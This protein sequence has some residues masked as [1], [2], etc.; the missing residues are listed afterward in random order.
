MATYLQ[1][2]TDYI[3]DYQPFQPNLNFYANLLQAKQTQYD[4][5]YKAINNLY[6]QLY[7]ADLTRTDNI[8]KKDNL[9]KQIDYNLKR[10]SGL[11]LSLQQNVDQATQVFRPFYDDKYLMKDMAWTK[12]FNNTYN[13]AIGLKNSS[14]EK[15]SK[16]YW[17]TGVKELQ[18]RREEFKDAA[19]DEA[20]NMASPTYTSYDN[21]MEK[22]LK[23]AKDLNLSVDITKPD[24]SGLYFIRQKNGELILPTL[25]KLFMST[26][27]TDPNLQKIYQTQA[28]VNRKDYIYQNADVEFNGDKLAAEKDYLQKEYDYLSTYAADSYKKNA[29]ESQ[30]TQSKITTVQNAVK[31]GNVNF[32]QKSYFEMLDQAFK[33]DSIAEEES[34]KINESVNGTTSST[35]STTNGQTPTLDL[36]NIELARIKIDG[37]RA[38]ILAQN[39]ILAAADVYAYKDYVTDI[40]VNSVGLEG[41]KHSNSVARLNLTHSQ[42]MQQIKYKDKLQ[43]QADAKKALLESGQYYRDSYVDPVTQEVI[44]G[45]LKLNEQWNNQNVTPGSSGQA[46]PEII[47]DKNNREKTV[48]AEDKLTGNYIDGWFVKMANLL[49]ETS[50]ANLTEK[51]VWGIMNGGT[52]GGTRFLS[53]NQ[54]V[55]KTP[56]KKELALEL[57]KSKDYKGTI[58]K[59]GNQYFSVRKNAKSD[60]AIEQ[61]KSYYNTWKNDKTEGRKLIQSRLNG[62]MDGM[63]EWVKKNSAL[64]EDYYDPSYAS[65]KQWTAV[66]QSYEDLEIINNKKIKDALIKSVGGSSNAKEVADLYLRVLKGG[67]RDADY[68]SNPEEFQRLLEVNGIDILKNEQGEIRQ[69]DNSRGGYGWKDKGLSQLTGDEQTELNR[70]LKEAEKTSPRPKGSLRDDEYNITPRDRDQIERNFL[71]KTFGVDPS[72]GNRNPAKAVEQIFNSF[73][74]AYMAVATSPDPNIGLMSVVPITTSAGGKA[75]LFADKSYYNVNPSI[76]GSMGAKSFVETFNDIMKINWNQDST[77]Y[78]VSDEGSS[79]TARSMGADL[80][81]SLLSELYNGF[82]PGSKVAPFRIEQSQIAMENRKLGAM[83]I[84]PTMEFLKEKVTSVYDPEAEAYTSDADAVK[85]QIQKLYNNGITFT[86]PRTEWTN[87]LFTGNVPT[88]TEQIINAKG[89]IEYNDINNAGN[90]VM[91]K[92]D[93]AGADYRIAYKLRSLQADGSALDIPMDPM[94]MKRG[95]NI[96]AAYQSIFST[97]SQMNQ[98]N[99]ETY[100]TFHK[101]NNVDAMKNAEQNFGFTPS[102]TGF[103]F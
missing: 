101:Q 72:T 26:Y 76:P 15:Q 13:S 54:V 90:F 66:C 21:A 94:N 99:L 75:A 2:V 57:Q 103:N 81:K 43:E 30:V 97:I 80:A 7:N 82:K 78:K 49:D 55:Q 48:E 83:T 68:L 19:A 92:V 17:D 47:I 41:L 24:P 86:A 64:A 25:Q 100:R 91:E 51:E 95:N 87:S 18:Y 39:D 71:G 38:N 56:I 16:K 5:N 44:V 62:V 12:N 10:V 42:K 98:A 46:G 63:D 52:R 61:F 34:K 1:G 67:A 4:S 65:A 50:G 53:G 69:I 3:P 84:Y 88:P 36:N 20:L 96:D 35:V 40:K 37:A 59:V 58:E 27:A 85:A 93:A 102:K 6:A 28:Y 45:P 14:D 73:N 11:D 31:E 9:L 70:L 23:I 22:Y 89:K 29:E 74:D 60:N 77:Q 32:K 79:I 8:E 33:V